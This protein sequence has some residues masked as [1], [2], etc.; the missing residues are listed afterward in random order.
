MKR[1]VALCMLL[2]IPLVLILAV[3]QS[4][5]Y[6]V[7]AAEIR[8]LEADQAR[9]IEENRKLLANIAVAGARRQVDRAMAEAEGYRRV[10]PASTLHILVQP[11]GERLDAGQGGG[12]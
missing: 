11:G 1:F 6:Q 10:G 8:A 2:S 7:V 5:R 9:W 3:A 12:L 4:G